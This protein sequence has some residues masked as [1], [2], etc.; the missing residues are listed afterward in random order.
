MSDFKISVGGKPI[1]NYSIRPLRQGT[2]LLQAESHLKEHRDGLDSLGV[3][4][5]GQDYLITGR[6]LRAHP[7]DL[8]SVETG[9]AV[10][11]VEFVEQEDNTFGEGVVAGFK[12]K[13]AGLEHSVAALPVLSTVAL[14]KGTAAAVRGAR[15]TEEQVKQLTSG[16]PLT[17][18]AL[19][20]FSP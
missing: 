5:D 17:L 11:R 20:D 9:Q 14:V 3:R 13:I 12:T 4:I 8:V 1:D 15:A 18:K 6:G 2:D 16:E 19:E 10:G 7:G